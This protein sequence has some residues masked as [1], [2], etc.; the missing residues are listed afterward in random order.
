MLSVFEDTLSGDAAECLPMSS[1]GTDSHKITARL[2]NQTTAFNCVCPS[3]TFKKLQKKKKKHVVSIGN[4]LQSA[5]VEQL[6]AESW[7]KDMLH[8]G[9]LKSHRQQSKC[10]ENA[11]EEKIM[12]AETDIANSKPPT[13]YYLCCATWHLKDLF[14]PSS[15]LHLLPPSNSFLWARATAVSMA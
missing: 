9:C 1:C 3:K 12:S 11:V 15:K 6:L 2:P 14:S 4:F 7:T 5:H 10:S 8:R 13:S